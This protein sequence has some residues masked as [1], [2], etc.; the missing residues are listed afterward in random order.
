MEIAA[1]IYCCGHYVQSN[2]AKV[3]GVRGKAFAEQH[4]FEQARILFYL[5]D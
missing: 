1:V 2:L 4:G 5:R 3:T